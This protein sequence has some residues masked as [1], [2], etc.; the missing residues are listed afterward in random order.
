MRIHPTHKLSKS[1]KFLELASRYDDLLFVLHDNPDPDGLASGWA[2]GEL[3]KQKLKRPFRL[4]ARGVVQRAENRQLLALL[5]PPLSLVETID[6]TPRSLVVL[7]DCRPEALNHLPVDASALAVVDHH[8]RPRKSTVPVLFEDIRPRVAASATI[9][10]SYLRDQGVILRPKLATALAYAI[11][12]EVAGGSVAFSSLDREMLSWISRCARSDLLAEIEEA[13]LPKRYFTDLTRALANTILHGDCAFCML[14]VVNAPETVSEVSDL[15]CRCE[16]IDAVLCCGRFD[17]SVK[18]SARTRR[19]SSRSATALVGEIVGELGHSGGHGHRA[20]GIIRLNDRTAKHA[21][22]TQE[23]RKRWISAC[24]TE[25]ESA[26]PLVR[27]LRDG[28]GTFKRKSER[29]DF[30]GTAAND[31]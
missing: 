20:G 25:G 6:P 21:W 3:V 14:P 15:L 12:T 22:F 29:S 23:L 26:T 13:P 1:D 19:K 18:L 28:T 31:A 17:D 5:K 8:E 10:A 4:L 2:L 7:V 9:A 11:R 30:D 24:G 27:P 16:G